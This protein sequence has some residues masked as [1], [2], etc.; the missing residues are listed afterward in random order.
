M[1]VLTL[2]TG[3]VYGQTFTTSESVSNVVAGTADQTDAFATSTANTAEVKATRTLNVTT[4][5]LTATTIVLGSCTVTFA[6]TTAGNGTEDTNCAGGATIL[7]TTNTSA[8]IARTPAQIATALRTLT[9]ITDTGHGALAM[10]AGTST[11]SFVLTTSGTEASATPITFT[12]GTTNKIVFLSST[13]GVI[14]V[15]EILTITISGTVDAGDVFSITTPSLNSG[16]AVTYT[17]SSSDT[18]TAN[19]ATGLNAAIQAAT[20]YGATLTSGASTNTVVLTAATAGTGFNI[21]AGTTNRAAV[22]Q[23]VTYN[24]G[25]ESQVNRSAYTATLN[26][27]SHTVTLATLQ[28][29]VESLAASLDADAAVTCTENDVLIT[30]TAD[31]AGTPFTYSTSVSTERSGTSGGGSS[32]K[33][34]KDTKVTTPTTPATI[35]PVIVTHT[36]NASSVKSFMFTQVLG[37]GSKNEDVRQLQ[38]RLA[39]EGVYTGP[40]TGYFGSLTASG[41]KAFQKKYNIPQLGIVGPMTKARLNQ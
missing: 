4:A 27:S 1:F 37:L 39:A 12:D 26:G 7:T 13:P 25:T 33:S 30:C 3:T 2:S 40:V 8:D 6:T 41:V 10:T 9:N 19:I 22:A 21:I 20:G 28:A 34:H 38:L 24:P 31:S 17:V 5:P 36:S 32:S 35:I 14:P 29:V 23:V 15:A 16:S 18:T 11:T